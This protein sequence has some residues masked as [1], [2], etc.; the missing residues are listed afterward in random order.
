M[1]KILSKCFVVSIVIST[2]FSCKKETNTIDIK[3]LISGKWTGI[4]KITKTTSQNPSTNVTSYFSDTLYDVNTGSNFYI[5]FNADSLS[6]IGHYVSPSSSVIDVSIGNIRY[7]INN[8][9]LS[10]PLN[11]FTLEGVINNSSHNSAKIFELTKNKLV[12]YDI[13]NTTQSLIDS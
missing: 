7:N 8:D 2:I 4:D 13:Y 12:L 5:E 11:P 3:S 9:I 1:R 10:F 6:S